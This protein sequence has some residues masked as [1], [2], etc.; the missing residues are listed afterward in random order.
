MIKIMANENDESWAITPGI[1]HETVRVAKKFLLSERG[2]TFIT[3]SPRRKIDYLKK[4]SP[5]ER[6][7]FVK[8]IRFEKKGEGFGDSKYYKN[9]SGEISPE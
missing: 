4:T 9:D 6:T 1:V 7:S 8:K 2:R 5:I 3:K